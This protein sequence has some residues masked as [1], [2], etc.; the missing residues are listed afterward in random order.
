MQNALSAPVPVMFFTMALRLTSVLPLL[1]D[2]DL[3]DSERWHR[4]SAQ[5]G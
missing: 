5:K 4:V 3:R 1:S 2:V